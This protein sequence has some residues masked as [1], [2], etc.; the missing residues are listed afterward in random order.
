M[1][2]H[3]NTILL[4]LAFAG[5][6]KSFSQATNN[7]A[8][9][10]ADSTILVAD[11]KHWSVRELNRVALDFLLDNGTMPK[12]LKLETV[13]RIFPRDT[14]TMCEFTYLQGFDQPSWEV[15]IGF[16]GTV[17]HFAK[18]IS[19]EGQPKRSQPIK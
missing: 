8:P 18:V 11:N 1:S 4:L 16:D 6:L 3:V 10:T 13:V 5:V 2:M 14:A 15:Q 17:K 12:G 7:I 19:R 9:P